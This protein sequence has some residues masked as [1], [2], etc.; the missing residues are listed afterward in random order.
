MVIKVVTFYTDFIKKK[1]LYKEVLED[2][3]KIILDLIIYKL[4]IPKYY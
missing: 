1:S 3:D 2:K 4:L